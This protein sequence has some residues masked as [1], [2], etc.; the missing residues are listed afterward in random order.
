[1]EAKDDNGR[2]DRQFVEVITR[3]TEQKNSTD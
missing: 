1:M 2:K 3:E